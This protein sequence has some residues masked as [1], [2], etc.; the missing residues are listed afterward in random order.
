M[1]GMAALNASRPAVDHERM[2]YRRA[3]GR[4]ASLAITILTLALALTAAPA[5]AQTPIP[6]PI[7]QPIMPPLVTTTT[8]AGNVAMLR[9]DGKAAIPLGAPKRAR[10][11]IRMANRIIGKPYK[12]G[13]GHAKLSDRGYDC[14][15]AVSFALIKAKML[16]FTMV[17]GGFK[18]WAADGAGRWISVYARK[19]HVYLEVAGL[20]FDTSSVG[21]FSERG[22]VQWRPVIGRRVGFTTRHPVGL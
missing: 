18:R 16:E 1:H 12:W 20:R 2:S 19:S 9:V 5:P 22:G 17:A 15:G 6:V 7:P 14:S 11:F 8:V 13:G 4:R 21:D 3:H 10:T